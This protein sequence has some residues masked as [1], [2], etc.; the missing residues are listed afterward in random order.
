[1]YT[2]VN[3]MVDKTVMRGKF[4]INKRIWIGVRKKLFKSRFP[5]PFPHIGK[6]LLIIILFISFPQIT[7]VP[8]IDNNI[9]HIKLKQ[10]GHWDW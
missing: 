1:M 10:E 2:N 8:F 5:I 3:P 7:K 6:L 4:Y 9:E